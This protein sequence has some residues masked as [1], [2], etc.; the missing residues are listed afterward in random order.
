MSGIRKKRLLKVFCRICKTVY[1]YTYQENKG[2]KMRNVKIKK[3]LFYD[4]SILIGSG[5]M[6]I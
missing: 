5:L 1:D 4:M 3:G 6:Y 2:Y